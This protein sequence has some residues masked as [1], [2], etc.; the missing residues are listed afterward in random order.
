MAETSE[1]SKI[2]VP[3]CSEVELTDTQLERAHEHVTLMGKVT[4]IEKPDGKLEYNSG[5]PSGKK[6]VVMPVDMNNPHIQD[7]MSKKDP[8]NYKPIR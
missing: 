5:T 8:G 3:V 2:G 6:T 7:K 4:V 1:G